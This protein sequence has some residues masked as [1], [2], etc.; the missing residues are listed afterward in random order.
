MF[1]FTMLHTFSPVLHDHVMIS[2][3]FLL[4][5]VRDYVCD[6]CYVS[7]LTRSGG[8]LLFFPSANIPYIPGFWATL[9]LRCPR[10]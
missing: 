1:M 4:Y 8:P 6:L 7:N 2:A 10:V 9:F 5:S 3:F